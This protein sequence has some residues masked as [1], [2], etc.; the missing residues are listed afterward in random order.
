MRPIAVFDI[1]GVL[2]DVAHRLHY[3]ENRPK[4]WKAFFAAA[5]ADGALS[6]GIALCQ[7]HA[8]DA[9]IRY[10]TG[11]PERLR[12]VTTRWLAQH[13]LPTGSLTMRPHRDFRPAVTFKRDWLRGWLAEGSEI[14]LVV[15]DDPTVVAMVK[16]LGLP[17]LAAD[18]QHAP[19]DEQQRLWQAQEEDGRT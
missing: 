17:V 5:D 9:E 13:S 19:R 11:R 8:V 4:D 12:S 3:V 2:A 10:L 18:W 14:S 6:P 15:D 16:E 7:Q 1:D